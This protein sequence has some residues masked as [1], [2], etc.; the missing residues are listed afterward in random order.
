[1]L[2]AASLVS[3][4]HLHRS[5]N[6]G[7]EPVPCQRSAPREQSRYSGP[8]SSRS[9]RIVAIGGGHG[10]STLLRGL[11]L[12]D[13]ELSAIVTVADDG[14]S[15][16]TLRREIGIL[17]PGDLRR[18]IGALAEVEP[19]MTLLFEYRFG[20]GAGLD[21]HAFGNLL[22]AALAGITGSF[23]AAIGEASRVLAVKGRILPSSLD[24]LE[25]Y[26]EVRAQDNGGTE[27]V[28]GQARIASSAG[29]IERVYIEP[30]AAKGFPEAIKALL[31]ADVI[32]I[33]PGSLYTSLLPNLLVREIRDAVR[34]SPAVRVSVC[35]VATQPGETDGFDVGDHVQALEEH[36]GPGFCDIV[37]ANATT[38]LEL[39]EASGSDMVAA[40][41]ATDG[42]CEILLLDLVDRELPWRH[43]SLKLADE[44][45]RVAQDRAM[46][47]DAD[48]AS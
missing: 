41:H 21:G 15:S 20:R 4:A 43:D 10:L 44:I 18:C 8:D 48:G 39:P 13:C 35:N 45:M 25:L 34:E 1:M 36:L 27:L 19:L 29:R 14:G 30:E 9:P 2:L 28:R 26:A 5:A 7:A 6:G 32:V 42:A 16:G 23:E 46:R 33:G 22:I 11:K 12:L 38:D 37:L 17:P 47:R 24:S 40:T 31:N 3:L